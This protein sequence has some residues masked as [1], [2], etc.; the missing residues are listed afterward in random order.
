MRGGVGDR[1]GPG[2]GD[3]GQHKRRTS[4]DPTMPSLSNATTAPPCPTR[5]RGKIGTE[6]SS[7]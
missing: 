7:G 3:K 2:G 5:S 4:N 6:V 1:E